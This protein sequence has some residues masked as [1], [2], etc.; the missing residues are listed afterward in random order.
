MTR[1]EAIK[2][3]EEII[4]EGWLISDF[5]KCTAIDACE[6]A[7]RALEQEPKTGHWIEHDWEKMREKGYY[8]CSVCDHAY[9][10]YVK[11]IRK[12]EVPYIDGQEYILWHN[13][14][15][16]PNC[17]AKMLNSQEGEEEDG[18]DG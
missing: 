17:G 11:G 5:D 6:M 16:C 1:E 10:R 3:L 18:N 2:I 12:S 14:N 15:Y 9:Q 4:D 13:D 8:R 7:I